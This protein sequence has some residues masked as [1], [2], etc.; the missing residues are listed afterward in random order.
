MAVMTLADGRQLAYEVMGDSNGYAVMALHGTPGSSRQLACLDKPARDH[1]VALI[2]PDRAGYGGSTHDRSRTMAS[3]AW[4]LGQLIEHLGLHD[5]AVIGLS[6][7]GPTALACGLALRDRI[8]S[9][10]TVGSIAPL[11]PRDPSLPPDRLVTRTARRSRRAA[12]AL[13][14]VMVFAGR[15][16][17]EQTLDRFCTLLAEPDAHLLRD[18][19]TVRRAFLDDLGHPSPTTARAAARD[20]WLFTRR[21]GIDL[22]DMTVPVHVW[23]GTEDRNVPVAHARVIAT[24]CPTARLHLIPGGGH[25]L[26]SNLEEIIGAMRQ[27]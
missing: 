7:G 23:H 6:G 2:I 10:T 22:A 21:W 12:R 3:S 27:V 24:R 26:L 4:D 1:N 18:D 13:F 20:F 17:P 19:R 25:M 14:A 5:A 15:L 11:V 9:V 8:R 16:R